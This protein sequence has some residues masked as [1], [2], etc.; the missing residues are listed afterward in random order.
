MPCWKNISTWQS[1]SYQSPVPKRG[2]THTCR[3]QPVTTMREPFCPQ[4][5]C[6]QMVRTMK[7][8]A[9][10]AGIFQA[11]QALCEEDSLVGDAAV[12]RLPGILSLPGIML[13]VPVPGKNEQS[14]EQ[15]LLYWKHTRPCITCASSMS[16]QSC[17]LMGRSCINPVH[18][19]H[20]YRR[21]GRHSGVSQ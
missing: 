11:S 5:P 17:H 4:F 20:Q 6:S 15:F 7:R 13:P 21:K 18:I 8:R 1:C 2:R 9:K 19:N 14:I 3:C 16:C 12:L 10:K